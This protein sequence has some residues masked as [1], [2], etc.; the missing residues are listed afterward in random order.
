MPSIARGEENTSG[1]INWFTAVNYVLTDMYLVEFRIFDISAGL[2]GSQVFPA[3]DTW[4]D[5]SAA[6][7]KFNTGSYYAY[8]NA[9]ACGW[10]PAVDAVLGDYRIY[11]RWKLESG[12]VYQTGAEDFVVTED[13]VAI[14]ADWL[15][16]QDLYNL[17]G[18]SRVQQLFDDTLIGSVGVTNEALQ[19]V[20][21]AAEGEAYSRMLRGWSREM[22]EALAGVDIAF[23]NHVAWVALEFASERRPAFASDDGKGQFWAQYERAIKFFENLSKGQ[24]RSIGESVAGAGSN[25]GGRLRPTST[26]K[27]VDSFIF[28]PSQRNPTGSGGF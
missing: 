17:V 23:R 8:D 3:G 12:S 27:Q 24:L 9:N 6:P 4:E 10:T 5:V 7:G 19:A 11:W 16:L 22:I 15:T 18:S 25:T 14:A 13:E 20:L 2:P 26:A 1:N 28:A 21:R